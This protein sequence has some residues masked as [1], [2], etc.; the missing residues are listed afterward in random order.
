MNLEKFDQRRSNLVKDEN[1]D[2]MEG[3]LVTYCMSL[4]LMM[5]D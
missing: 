4:G 5:L 2:L 1:C 3:L